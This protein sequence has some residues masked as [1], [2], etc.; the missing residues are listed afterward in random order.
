MQARDTAAVL[1]LSLFIDCHGSPISPISY[2][3]NR[4]LIAFFSPQALL[5]LT[6]ALAD[7]EFYAFWK[8]SMLELY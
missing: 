7:A 3:I 8:M 4:V 5:G 6:A 1:S 2:F